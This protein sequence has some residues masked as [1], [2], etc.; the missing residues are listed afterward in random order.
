GK[1]A[2]YFFNPADLNRINRSNFRN[3][4][5]IIPDDSLNLYRKSG[6]WNNL[7][8]IRKYQITNTTMITPPISKIDA[9]KSPVILPA[10]QN[11]TINGRIYLFRQ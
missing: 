1:Q 10:V 6:I 2:V 7:V 11:I 4:Y 3:I 5:L 9:Y 8:P